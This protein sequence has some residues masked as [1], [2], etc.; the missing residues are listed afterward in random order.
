M[1]TA[2]SNE[3]TR[4]TTT[5]SSGDYDLA[6]PP[7][8]Y[9]V[10]VTAGG[11]FSQT[12]SNINVLTDTVTTQ[13]FALT[14]AVGTL[15]RSENTI[16]ETVMMGESVTRTLWVSN[17]GNVAFNFTVSEGAAWA[18]V[19]PSGGTLDPG[20]TM[21]LS[22]VFDSSATAGAG[23]YNDALTFSGSYDNSPADVTLTLHV[24][25]ES[26]YTTY[27][28]MVVGN[29]GTAAPPANPTAALPW[30]LPLFGLVIGGTGWLTTRLHRSAQ[31]S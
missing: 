6:L 2:E 25:E 7:G 15:E 16:E 31:R 28:P 17:T 5:D 19:T 21:A 20:E 1:V 8:A 18:E 11:Y 14:V 30:L 12:V 24:T 27:L 22:V 10:T 9:D 23:T 4:S 13:D 29:G 3:D 26:S